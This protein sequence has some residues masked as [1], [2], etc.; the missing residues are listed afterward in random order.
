MD[1]VDGQA[2]WDGGRTSQLG[3]ARGKVGRVKDKGNV[4]NKEG[5]SG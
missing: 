1:L 2:V 4:C 3:E 5:R